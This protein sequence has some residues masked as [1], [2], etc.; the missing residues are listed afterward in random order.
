MCRSSGV[1]APWLGTS[2]FPLALSKKI[3]SGVLDS[4]Y[5][6]CPQED[7][8]SI[9]LLVSTMAFQRFEKIMSV[10][11]LAALPLIATSHLQLRH[12]H[13]NEPHAF[14]SR[15]SHDLI[16][17]LSNAVFTFIILT[18]SVAVSSESRPCQNGRPT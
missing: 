15:H 6:L 7:S 9:K 17:R 13:S 10:Q 5:G 11:L 1:F 14:S 8:P 18:G 12:M 4:A 2:F 3:Y 16:A